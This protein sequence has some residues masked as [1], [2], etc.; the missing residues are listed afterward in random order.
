MIA[1]MRLFTRLTVML[2]L[3]LQAAAMAAQ[4]RK[5]TPV[6]TDDK[7]P[8]QPVLHYY[9]KHGNPLKD[10]VLFLSEL[11]TVQAVKSRPVYPALNGASVGFNFFDLAMKAFGQ[12][13]ANVDVWADLSI[14][15]WLFPTVEAGIGFG[16]NNPDDGNYRYKAKPSVYVKLGANY[17]FL[18]K[19][20]PDY[21]AFLGVR[22]GYSSF[23][24]DI[25]GISVGT[26]YWGQT[27]TFDLKGQRASAFYGEVL[28]GIKVKIYR[29]LSLGWTA[30]YHFM[31]HRGDGS[32]STPWLIPGYGANNRLSATFSIIYTLPLAKQR[33]GE[34]AKEKP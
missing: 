15:N 31:F 32:N 25:Y 17:N 24:Y 16:E 3:L 9:D 10:P 13:Y 14:H 18:Y 27:N 4:E 7:K 33:T 20:N 22:A 19:S 2:M 1:V 26:D 6:E 8:Q 29:R 34:G 12:R 5:I 30:R 11:D 21:Q 28:A 23:K